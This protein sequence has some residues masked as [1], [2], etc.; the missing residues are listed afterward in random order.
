MTVKDTLRAVG[1]TARICVPTVAESVVGRVSLDRC[2]ERLAWWAHELLREAD[3]TLHVRGTSNVP[4]GEPLVVMSNHRSYYDIP[5]A[6][7]AIPGRL[8]MV[9]KKELF[10]VPLFGR[11][12]LASGFIKVDRGR[13]DKAIESLRESR[14]LLEGGTRV[15]IAPEGTRSKDGKLG[16][17]KAG[18]FFLALEAGVRILPIVVQGTE[19]VMPPDGVIVHKGATVT[20]DILP[21]IDT[22]QYGIKRRKE[23]M[24]DVRAAMTRVLGD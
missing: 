24:A 5:A 14:R 23:L 4:A 10:R 17:F 6:F 15:W 16:P 21:P 20:V 8:R 18:G 7:C 1:L 9:A 13:R 2:D 12:M 19:N 22:A 3:V 11:A